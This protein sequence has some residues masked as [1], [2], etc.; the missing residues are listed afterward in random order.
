MTTPVQS[1]FSIAPSLT[2]AAPQPSSTGQAAAFT[3]EV[4]RAATA[5]VYVYRMTDTATGRI[6]VEIPN[7][8][9]TPVPDSPGSKVD[10]K[11]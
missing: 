2:T 8:P 6:L 3:V 4:S 10:A 9:T 5:P 11:V 1:S 7:D